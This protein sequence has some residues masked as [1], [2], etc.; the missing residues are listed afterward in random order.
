MEPLLLAHRLTSETNDQSMRG[1]CIDNLRSG[2]YQTPGSS[3]PSGTA[4]QRRP[5]AAWARI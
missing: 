4:G 2:V 5:R 1:A 3:W